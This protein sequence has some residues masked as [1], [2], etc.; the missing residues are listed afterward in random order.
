MRN[1]KTV[2]TVTSIVAV[3][4]VIIGVTYAYWLVTKTQT[5][6]NLISS[7]CLD[8]TLNG[9][10][11]DI[12]LTNQFPL[13]DEDGMKLTPYEFTVTNNCTTSVDYQ[14][15]LESIGDSTNAIKASAI[16]VALNDEIKLLTAGGNAEPTLSE[17]YE[18]N[19]ILYG[20]LA[21][22]SEE[23][24]DDT[25]TYELRIWIDANAPISE[26]NKTFTSKIS[27]TAGQGVINPYKEGTLAYD[28]LSNY[29][30]ADSISK[31][32]TKLTAGD[33]NTTSQK[34][35]WEPYAK[36]WYGSSYTFDEENGYTL[37]GVLTQATL[38]ECRNGTK[39]CGNYTFARTEPDYSGIEIYEITSF[40]TGSAVSNSDVTFKKIKATNTF[41]NVIGDGEV[42][43]YKAK[44]DLGTSYYFRGD[45]EN[46]HVK[47]G[48]E[49]V[50]QIVYNSDEIVFETK[51][52]DKQFSNME[53]CMNSE[54]FKN[55]DAE[56]DLDV[57]CARD[58]EATEESYILFYDVGG[59]ETKKITD[60][61]KFSNSLECLSSDKYNTLTGV[62]GEENV[63]CEKTG[64]GNPIYWRIVRINGDGTIRM[65]F[66]GNSAIV[67]TKYNNNYDNS[68]Y[69]GY[70]YNDGTGKQADSTIKGLVDSWYKDNLSEKYG[71]YIADGI[72]CNDREIAE[73]VEVYP[74]LYHEYYAPYNRLNNLSPQLTCPNKNDR[75][76]V[77]DKIG[78][79]LLTYP[80]SLITADEVM[81]AGSLLNSNTSNDHYMF[82]DTWTISPAFQAAESY[83]HAYYSIGNGKLADKYLAWTYDVRPVINLKADVKFTGNGRIDTNS[84][85]E[86]VME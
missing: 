28:I 17:A 72:F 10:K 21:E 59:Y 3:L 86:I 57:W 83:I 27:V 48:V 67:E 35:Y 79:G 55:A 12:E 58:T 70:T 62:Y 20:T 13:S 61:A 14:V 56:T 31:I 82:S 33:T 29:G 8:I 1:K 26:M 41:A 34:E 38:E 74:G 46:N 7:G 9:E 32:N 23:T 42:G 50:Y 84:P 43:L 15:N 53:E 71:K 2:I 11:N 40:G 6:Q 16:K 37:S 76:T 65:I 5:N 30:G 39:N 19:M 60:T 24:T 25:I 36:Y 81:F 54:E 4:L 75:Y 80:V 68:K 22:S 49:S 52:V 18:S 66:D 78:N 69:V 85:Y 44:D 63:W 77:N 45:V 73:K 51:K 64:E 47:F